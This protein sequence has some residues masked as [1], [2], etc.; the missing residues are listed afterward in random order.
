MGLAVIYFQ[1]GGD[2]K[3]E[4][5]YKYKCENGKIVITRL[6]DRMRT[7]PF[8]IEKSVEKFEKMV[9]QHKASKP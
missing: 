5:Q 3:M 4:K 7:I 6:R 9:Q 2:E 1:K 8:C